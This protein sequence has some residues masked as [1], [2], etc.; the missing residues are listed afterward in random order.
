MQAIN[1][2]GVISMEKTIIVK[3]VLSWVL[4]I[5]AALVFWFIFY[6]LGENIYTE[7]LSWIKIVTLLIPAPL[8]SIV[9]AIWLT[10]KEWKTKRKVLAIIIISLVFLLIWS[11]ILFGVGWSEI[12]GGATSFGGFGDAVGY[13]IVFFFAQMII[14]PLWAVSDAYLYFSGRWIQMKRSKIMTILG[15]AGVLIG[16]VMWMATAVLTAG[17]IGWFAEM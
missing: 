10:N 3:K 15:I 1:G 2:K 6:I 12:H 7:S 17:L 8:I 4:L 16:T 11:Y 13:V 14:A 9:I 5:I